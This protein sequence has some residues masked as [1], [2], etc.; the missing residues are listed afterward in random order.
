M[1]ASLRNLL[2]PRQR[3]RQPAAAMGTLSL[4][5]EDVLTTR[6]ACYFSRQEYLDLRA[7][8]KGMLGLT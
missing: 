3:R 5:P 7:A 8:S 4:I 1:L 6:V 2:W